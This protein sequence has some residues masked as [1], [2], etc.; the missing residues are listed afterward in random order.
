MLPASPLED[1]PEG[2]AW[3]LQ[4]LA[5]RLPTPLLLAV[6]QHMPCVVVARLAC[7]HK[8]YLSA[9]QQLRTLGPRARWEPPSEANKAWLPT[10]APLTHAAWLGDDAAV[11]RL[12]ARRGDVL[13]AAT[14][15]LYYATLHG[16]DIIVAQL[17]EAGADVHVERDEALHLA[18]RCGHDTIV[19]QLLAAGADVHAGDGYE[20]ACVLGSAAL[21]G[22][23]AIVARLLAAGANVHACE[24]EALRLAALRGHD[25]VV[26][27]LLA[28]GADVHARGAE[29]LRLAAEN[30]HAAVVARLRAAGG[31]HAQ[32]G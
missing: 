21:E 23:D 18:A 27:R 1:D 14:D 31:V 11:A 3:L 20:C 26:A 10:L 15:A 17:L 19:A 4:S 7:V 5:T 25:A 24:D 2:L 8:A 12:L 29:A 16:D 30:G 6:M 28:A 22:H 32:D 13:A 9:W